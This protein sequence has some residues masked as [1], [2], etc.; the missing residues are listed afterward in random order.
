[1]KS[2]FLLVV[3]IFFTLKKEE[4]KRKKRDKEGKRG[5]GKKGIRKEM[6]GASA[7]VR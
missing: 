3:C 2:H 5:K 7:E 6:A 4:R 1:M